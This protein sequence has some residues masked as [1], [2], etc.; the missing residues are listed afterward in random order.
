MPV[1]SD[2]RFFS[3]TPRMSTCANIPRIRDA[4]SNMAPTSP[5]SSP[6]SSRARDLPYLA[7]VAR[8]EWA[9]NIGA[10]VR[11]GHPPAGGD[12]RWGTANRGPHTS[13]FACSPHSATSPRPGR[14]TRSGRPTKRD[15]VP[16]IDIT[17]GG[18]SL[19]IRARRR[20]GPSGGGSTQGTFA[21]RTALADGPCPRCRSGGRDPE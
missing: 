13:R 19:E 18:T 6:V 20:G 16:S 9:L 15:E 17:S 1:W 8:L 3:P 21:F 14:S 12:A 5:T 11:G 7:D 4:S 10:T 2:K